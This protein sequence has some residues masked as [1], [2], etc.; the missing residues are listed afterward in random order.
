MATKLIQI[1][2]SESTKRHLPAIKP[3]RGD[4][5][6]LLRTLIW[7]YHNYKGLIP[8]HLVLLG[9]KMEIE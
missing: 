3:P 1:H 9:G 7:F 6:G 5:D 4:D 2:V 8:R